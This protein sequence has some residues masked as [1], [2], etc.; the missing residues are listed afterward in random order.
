MKSYNGELG[1]HLSVEIYMMRC[2]EGVHKGMKEDVAD[3]KSRMREWCGVHIDGLPLNR[4][5]ECNE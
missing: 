3:E 5:L 2:G 1:A 4:K